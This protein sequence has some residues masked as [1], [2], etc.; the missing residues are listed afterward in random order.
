R[1]RSSRGLIGGSKRHRSKSRSRSRSRSPRSR[2]HRSRSRSPR[3]RSPPRRN[4]RSRHS[5]HRSRGSSEERRRSIEKRKL[6]DFRIAEQRL[7]KRHKEYEEEKIQVGRVW[8]LPAA[9]SCEI[10]SVYAGIAEVEFFPPYPKKL[11]D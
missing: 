6:E 3:R 1:D 7:K 9:C 8:L 2:R 5:P 11:K 4:D 10:P